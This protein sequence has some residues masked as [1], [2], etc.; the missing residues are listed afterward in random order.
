PAPTP[1][2]RAR[3]PGL[4]V[5]RVGGR[6]LERRRARAPRQGP[7]ARRRPRG[8]RPRAGRRRG[9]PPDLGALHAVVDARRLP[10]DA[11]LRR[12]RGARRPRRSRPVLGPAP[13]A[14]GLAPA[15]ELGP[16]PLPRPARR[17]RLLLPVDPP[18]SE[19]GRVAGGRAGRGRTGG[20]VGRG[21]GRD[22]RPRARAGPA[23][24]GR[25]TAAPGGGSARP[26]PPAPAPPDRAVVLLSGAHR[27]PV[28]P[29][30]EVGYSISL[31]GADHERRTEE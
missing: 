14:S 2:P 7:H 1:A 30:R 26:R 28:G 12:R 9:A 17:A 21:P 6:V 13:G 16:A 10:G 23:D 22:V 20:G 15:R 5:H 31:K 25:A 8:G 19:D 27:G 4:R 11:R 24:G 3:G 29:S 18:G